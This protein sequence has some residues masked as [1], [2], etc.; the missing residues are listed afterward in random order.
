L[1]GSQPWPQAANVNIPAC[2]RQDFAALRS[3]ALL[4]ESRRFQ[5]SDPPFAKGN[6][7]ELIE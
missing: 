1:A 5:S 4:S 2:N 3:T 7:A 6:S